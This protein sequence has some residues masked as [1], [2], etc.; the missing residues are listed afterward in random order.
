MKDSRPSW[1]WARSLPEDCP[2]GPC[3]SRWTRG[4]PDPCAS[5]VAKWRLSRKTDISWRNEFRFSLLCRPRL[6]LWVFSVVGGRHIT[7][8]A[9]KGK[10][11]AI[12]RHFAAAFQ[13]RLST[14]AWLGWKAWWAEVL[15]LQSIHM[16]CCRW[17]L[18]EN[19]QPTHWFFLRNLNKI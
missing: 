2:P 17:S 16:D 6:R 9:R 18:Q 7:A 14:P 15:W 12:S 1:P 5:C 11:S 10:S 19:L 13:A 8:K 3:R 4:G